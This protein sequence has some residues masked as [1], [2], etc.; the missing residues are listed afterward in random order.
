MEIKV[1]C[2]KL[3][4]NQDLQGKKEQCKKA[5]VNDL[6]MIKISFWT[7]P[8]VKSDKKMLI[9]TM[10]IRTLISFLTQK[11]S[12]FLFLIYYL[13]QNKMELIQVKMK[14]IELN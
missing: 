5:E 9:Q 11:I 3:K 7:F 4:F 6:P 2:H 12:Q 10:N 14:S 1:S 13:Q 8:D